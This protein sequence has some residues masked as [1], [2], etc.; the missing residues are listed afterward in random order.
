MESPDIDSDSCN[1][2]QYQTVTDFVPDSINISNSTETSFMLD[3]ETI[4]EISNDEFICDS[5]NFTE[6]VLLGSANMEISNTMSGQ[7]IDEENIDVVFDVVV[8][9]CDGFGCVAVEA[10]LTFPCPVTLSTSASN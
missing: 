6:S 2:D 5:Q 1:L 7:I 10:V 3:S 9:S 4:C 8:E